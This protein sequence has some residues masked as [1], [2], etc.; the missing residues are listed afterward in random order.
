MGL[1]DLAVTIAD[2]S[3]S[4]VP[5]FCYMYKYLTGTSQGIK[6]LAIYIPS[7]GEPRENQ[8]GCY[9]MVIRKTFDLY[10]RAISLQMPAVW[11]MRKEGFTR[12][13]LASTNL[14]SWN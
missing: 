7:V 6:L 2:D 8:T 5:E 12:E 10:S 14:Y 9:L 3:Q 13:D 11:K 1:K 4:I